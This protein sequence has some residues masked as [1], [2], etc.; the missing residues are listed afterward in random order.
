MVH[1]VTRYGKLNKMLYFVVVVVV[2]VTSVSADCQPPLTPRAGSSS[3]QVR[4]PVSS[5]VLQP[6]N[7]QVSC[8]TLALPP[9]S[10]SVQLI[11]RLIK[12]LIEDTSVGRC[13][14]AVPPVPIETGGLLVALGGTILPGSDAADG[15]G[16]GRTQEQPI[17]HW[18]GRVASW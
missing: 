5:P 14:V 18:T 11:S 13:M 4:P 12:S 16:V 8:P 6:Y 15:L 17:L 2:V 3:W 1:Q 7:A 10:Y 9:A